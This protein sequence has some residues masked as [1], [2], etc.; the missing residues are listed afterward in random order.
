MTDFRVIGDIGLTLKALLDQ[1]ELWTDISQKPDITFQSPKEIKEDSDSTGN[2][3]KISL[4]LYHIEVNPHLRNEDLIRV[5]DSGF[6]QPPLPLYLYYLVTPYGN[7]KTDEHYI[8]GKVMQIF[9]DNPRLMG[10]ILQN[11]L[12]ESDEEFKLLFSTISLDDL[13]KVWDAFQDVAFRLSVGY[14]VTPIRIVS[15]KETTKVQRVIES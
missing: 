3:N 14:M 9:Y 11:S 8:L 7:N 1:D 5:N 10:S 6:M 2:P 15:A 12:K 13:Y 4:F